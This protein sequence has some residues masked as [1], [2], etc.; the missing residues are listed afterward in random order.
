MTETAVRKRS[1]GKRGTK[2]KVALPEAEGPELERR[3]LSRADYHRAAELGIFGPDER[4]ELIHGEVYRKISP[5]SRRHARGVITIAVTLEEA[6]GEGFHVQQQLPLAMADSEPEPDVAVLSGD[7]DD[8]KDQHPPVSA[9]VLV[10]EISDT[11]LKGDRGLKAALYAE[12]GVT[13][14]W[15]VNLNARAVEVYR[16][17][18]ALP[19][20]P[21]GFGYKSVRLYLEDETVSPLAKPEAA[22]PVA[23]LLPAL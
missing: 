8:Y 18:A 23:R 2:P 13:D 7:P 14:Y 1:R 12:A 15:I 11:S 4:L 5:Q 22:I 3:K 21:H 10:V 9:A 16:E 19:N 17:P 20:A 6:F